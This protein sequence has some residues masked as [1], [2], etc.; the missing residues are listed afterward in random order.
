MQYKTGDRQLISDFCKLHAL[1]ASFEMTASKWFIPLIENIAT[2]HRGAKR[3]IFVGINGCQG[4]GKS[5]LSAF[6]KFYLSTR[7]ELNVISI[8]LD[9]F[10]Y[11]SSERLAL[12]IKIHPLLATRGVPGTHNTVLIKRLF[13]K[14]VEQAF[15]YTL[16]QFNKATDNP[17]PFDLWPKVERPVD[18]ALMEGWCWGIEPQSIDALRLPINKLE[19]NDDPMGVWRSFVNRQ[20]KQE[21]RPLYAYMDMWVML[22]APSFQNVLG[23]RIEQ[24]HRLKQAL[25]PQCSDNQA[26]KGLMDD[27]QIER[28]IAHYQRLTEHA[29]ST[30]AQ[31]CDLTF[32]LDNNR[33]INKVITK[34]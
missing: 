27:V 26:L 10:Y 25:L 19:E 12:S 9:D 4:S 28:F 33:Q 22:K 15:D 8:S 23:W 20:L 6:I 1:P 11:S 31:H 13:D 3:P 14:I 30:L 17:V 5:T 18:I 7:T 16:P 34:S 32:R 29:L 24:E 21:Y 2:H